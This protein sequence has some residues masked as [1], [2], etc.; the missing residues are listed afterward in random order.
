M[1]MMEIEST[2]WYV[3]DKPRSYVYKLQIELF[4]YGAYWYTTGATIGYNQ[5]TAPQKVP[6]YNTFLVVGPNKVLGWRK[7]SSEYRFGDVYELFRGVESMSEEQDID[8]IISNRIKI[9]E[10]EDLK[11]IDNFK[12]K[13]PKFNLIDFEKI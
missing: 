4:K 5:R 2:K 12:L 10:I 1:L 8:S 6:L 11:V 7:H 13:V 9:P 3:K